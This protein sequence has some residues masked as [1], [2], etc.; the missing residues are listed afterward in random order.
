MFTGIIEELG[1][2]T[3][4]SPLS[5]GLEMTIRS[6][7]LSQKLRPGDSVS[8]DGACQTVVLVQKHTFSIQAVG[9]TLTKSTL[10]NFK[11]GREVNLETS[12]TLETPLGG[13]IVQGH[14]Q[15]VGKILKWLKRGENYALEISIPDPLMKYCVV[16]GS[17]AIDGISLTIA[18]LHENSI[19]I[20]IIPFTVKQTTL[21]N[22]RIGDT[23][24]I[25]TDIIARYVER[26][27][28]HMKNTGVS[29][30]K[31]RNWGY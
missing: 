30:E 22:R 29:W 10:G 16:E 19:G 20:S 7:N 26:F 27:L 2:I 17:I 5:D 18:E 31:L 12:I 8:I 28:P 21:R 3:S 1:T 11:P 25:E 13:H 15:G 6:E 9:E 24:N 4:L 23:V 14:V